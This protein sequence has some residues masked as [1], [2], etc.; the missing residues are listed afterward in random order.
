MAQALGIFD[1]AS[2]QVAGTLGVVDFGPEC[3]SG[4]PP[5]SS[6]FASRLES[7]PSTIWIAAGVD[8]EDGSPGAGGTMPDARVYNQ[9]GE[10]LGE[11]ITNDVISSEKPAFMTRDQEEQCKACLHASD[12][13]SQ[14]SPD[15]RPVS[16]SFI[17]LA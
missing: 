6:R 15:H 4:H 1:T 2:G 7:S 8:A 5:R 10:L 12:V 3:F 14:T 11:S 17:T 13:R 16:P 9:W